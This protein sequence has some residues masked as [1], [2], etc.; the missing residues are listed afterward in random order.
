MNR[1]IR[2]IRLESELMF[3]SSIN[4]GIYLIYIKN[5]HVEKLLSDIQKTNLQMVGLKQ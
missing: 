5:T 2:K 4:V 1:Y 3:L